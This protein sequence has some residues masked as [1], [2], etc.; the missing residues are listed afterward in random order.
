M[1]LLHA[2]RSIRLRSASDGTTSCAR[3]SPPGSRT[4]ATAH[5]TGR[6]RKASPPHWHPV[7]SREAT[8][9]CSDLTTT[10]R[11]HTP[12][13]S[14]GCLCLPVTDHLY[15][16]EASDLLSLIDAADL[17]NAFILG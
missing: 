17:G 7:R 2:S 11:S 15:H 9:V 8:P 1:A 6:G 3:S 4:T 13:G 14:D 16:G 12:T 5:G 10:S